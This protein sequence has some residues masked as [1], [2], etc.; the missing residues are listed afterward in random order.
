MFHLID[1]CFYLQLVTLT[2]MY[3]TPFLSFVH[4]VQEETPLFLA[5]REGSFKTVKVLLDHYA[6]RDMTD[7]MDQL[8]R[9]VAMERQHTDIVELL[10]NYKL[11]SPASVHLTGGAMRTSGNSTTS[12]GG[13]IH[14]NGGHHTF[15]H[16]DMVNGYAMPQTTKQVKAKGRKTKKDGGE[17]GTRA[18]GVAVPKSK[19]KKPV[20]SPA[21]QKVQMKQLQQAPTSSPPSALHNQ[22]PGVGGLNG[23][24][25]TSSAAQ[26]H[27]QAL[28]ASSLQQQQAQLQQHS[29]LSSSN[30]SS[31]MST[32]SPGSYSV[33]SHLSPQGY[34]AYDA[35]VTTSPLYDAFQTSLPPHMGGG[36]GEAHRGLEMFASNGVLDD[37]EAMAT[38]YGESSLLNHASVD[39]LLTELSRTQ[40]KPQIQLQQSQQQQLDGVVKKQHG[41]IAGGHTAVSGD[42]SLLRQQQQQ[43]QVKGKGHLPMSPTLYQ[44]MQQHAQ[45]RAG[46]HR[47]PH[48]RGTAMGGASSFHSDGNLP[49]VS[50]SQQMYAGTTLQQQQQ[51]KMHHNQQQHHQQQHHLQQTQQQQQSLPLHQQHNILQQTSL[52]DVTNT[53]ISLSGSVLGSGHTI[54]NYPSPR[55][56]FPTPPSH[57]SQHLTDSPPHQP[58]PVSTSTAVCNTATTTTTTNNSSSNNN[59]A[60]PPF[61][62][63]H[64]L[65]SLTPSPDS[66]CGWSS[67]PHSDHSGWSG[68]EGISS[69]VPPITHAPHHPRHK[70]LMPTEQ[71]YF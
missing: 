46:V 67:S 71:A 44:A 31:P 62:P 14:A 66:P 24:G 19:K 23:H 10:D 48:H 39:T 3:L 51:Q 37:L 28:N 45:Q 54:T 61:R 30:D 17:A 65:L 11:A 69:P 59:S 20:T 47:S 9:D 4:P 25:V 38:S 29:H 55:E 53:P 43:Q 33:E 35:A 34:E 5:A 70:R 64:H 13:S 22:M 6:N 2:L 8:P 56:Q 58:H 42:L 60:F 7:H 26:N 15:G 27:Q 49:A 1:Y 18:A 52:A 21:A 12:P 16:Q 36:S 57:N 68:S 40:L 50:S 41:S 63:D 32:I